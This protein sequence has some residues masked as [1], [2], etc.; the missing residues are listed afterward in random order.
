VPERCTRTFDEALLSGYVDRALTQMEDQLVR[1]H[2]EDCATCRAMVEDMTT[3]REA[4][5]TSE[6]KVP[7]DTQWSERPRGWASRT[8][9]AAGWLLVIGWAVGLTAYG[10]WEFSRSPGDLAEKLV[11]AGGVSG[12]ALLLLGVALDRLKARR[13]DRYRE[14]QK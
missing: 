2:L 14:V 9:L 12:F 10:L 3:L 4:V 11:L 6:F 7:E 13:T 5:M 1:V 8:S